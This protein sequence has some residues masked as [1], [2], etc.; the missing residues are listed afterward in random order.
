MRN[1]PPKA[2]NGRLRSAEWFERHGRNTEAA[3]DRAKLD[4][5]LRARAAVEGAVDGPDALPKAA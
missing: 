5:S 1:I 2:R 4:G 3:G